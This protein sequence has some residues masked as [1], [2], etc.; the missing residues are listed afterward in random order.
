MTKR[1]PYLLAIL[2]VALIA[3]GSSSSASEDVIELTNESVLADKQPCYVRATT[4]AFNIR[5]IT[6]WCDVD[7]SDGGH[8]YCISDSEPTYCSE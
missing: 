2:T 5:G 4:K 8:I 6:T 1:V 7:I 3:W